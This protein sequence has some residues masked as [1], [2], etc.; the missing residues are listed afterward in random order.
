MLQRL[1]H[2]H[3]QAVMLLQQQRRAGAGG[4]SDEAEGRAQQDAAD[5]AR[6]CMAGIS[7][8]SACKTHAANLR[9]MVRIK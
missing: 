4:G 6:Q 7:E 9:K 1:C 8:R 2:L 3:L 5:A